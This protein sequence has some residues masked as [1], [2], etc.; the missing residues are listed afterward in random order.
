M[1]PLVLLGSLGRVKHLRGVPRV[2]HCHHGVVQLRFGEQ[3][4]CACVQSRYHFARTEHF[5]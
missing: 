5:S 2:V 3:P 4:L 1:L